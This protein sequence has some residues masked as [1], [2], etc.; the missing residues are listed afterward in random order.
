M[1]GGGSWGGGVCVCMCGGGGGER[2]RYKKAKSHTQ[3]QSERERYNKAR[4]SGGSFTHR[5]AAAG[6]AHVGAEV[7]ERVRLDDER[8]G[9]GVLVLLQHLLMRYE[10]DDGGGGGE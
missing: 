7:G 6:V 4:S 9:R 10:L 3:R 5:G 8:D 1:E 2:E